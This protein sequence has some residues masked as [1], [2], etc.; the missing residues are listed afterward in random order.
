[1]GYRLEK[2]IPLHA[3]RRPL[4]DARRKSLSPGSTPATQEHV[5]RRSRLQQRGLR[6]INTLIRK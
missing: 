2:A 3:L 6:F 5:A 4:E 1:M